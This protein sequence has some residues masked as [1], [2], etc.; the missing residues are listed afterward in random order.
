MRNIVIT[1]ATSFIGVNLIQEFLK[2]DDNSEYK[3]YAVVRHASPKVIL[4]PEDDRLTIIDADMSEYDQLADKVDDSVYG[5][6]HL[7]WNGTRGINRNDVSLQ[8]KNYINSLKALK[9]AVE[10]KVK[11]FVSAG[12]QAEYG[13]SS[14]M[15]F[16]DTQVMPQTEYGK[17]K[18]KFYER[19]RKTCEEHKI[20]F[21]EPR[22]FS[23]YGYG[24]F[25][26]TLV[27]STLKRM[28]KNESCDLTDCTQNWNFLHVKDAA[29][30]IKILMHNLTYQDGIY[31]FGSKN[32]MPLKSFVEKMKQV[33]KSESEL[34]FGAVQHNDS[35]NI[36]LNPCVDKL[37]RT[38]WQER[39]SFDDGIKELAEQLKGENK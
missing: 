1:G 16:E 14:N 19:A 21:Y 35:G 11:V 23:L 2:K 28:L 34:N 25:A 36:G 8:E 29:R 38:G 5:F 10:L 33:S 4:L 13:P 9:S 22:F 37:S 18:L 31:N 15:T 7:A 17:F 26:Q 24:D 30:G 39:I 20:K 27:I 6:V 3:V 32:T 12:S